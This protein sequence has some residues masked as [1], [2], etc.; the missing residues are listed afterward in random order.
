MLLNN[1]VC[2]TA[3]PRQIYQVSKFSNDENFIQLMVSNK[4]R[5]SALY[6]RFF[7]IN[8][9]G[10]LVTQDDN[11]SIKHFDSLRLAFNYIVD[12]GDDCWAFMKPAI[13]EFCTNNGIDTTFI[14]DD[15]M[16]S[17]PSEYD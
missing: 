1:I 15:R 3:D 2:I 5:D 9:D 11:F 6:G 7:F 8:A 12:N 17:L 16:I 14:N 13:V 4:D 10:T